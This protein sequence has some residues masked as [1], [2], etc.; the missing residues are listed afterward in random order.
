MAVK[1]ES[2]DG[3]GEIVASVELVKETPVDSIPFHSLGFAE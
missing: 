2:I 1:Q 3:R